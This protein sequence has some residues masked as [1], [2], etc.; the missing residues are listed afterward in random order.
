MAYGTVKVNFITFDAGSGDQTITVADLSSLLTS[1]ITVTGAINAQSINATSGTFTNVSGNTGRINT[2]TGTTASF[3]TGL[4]PN[5]SGSYVQYASGQI[6]NLSG[7]VVSYTSG[8]ITNVSG[9]YFEYVS[10][11][12]TTLSGTTLIGTL[13]GNAD[14]AARLTSAQNFTLSGDIT[15]T[16]SSN[17]ASGFVINTSFTSGIIVNDDISAGANIADTKLGTISTAGKVSNSATT[18]TSANTSSAIVARD[19]AGNFSANIIT[20]TLSGSCT[21]NAATA[22][23]LSSARNFALTGDV[24]GTVSSD[25]TTGFSVNTAIASG[26][27]V[28]ADINASAGIV[29][30]KLATITTVGKVANSATTATSANTVSTIVARDGL[31]NFSAGVITATL[32]G[33]ASTTTQLSSARTFSITGDVIGSVSSDLATGADITVGIASGVIV[34]A[35]INAAAAI[36]P[37]KLGTGA[38]P[39]SVTVAS[40]NIVDG[41]IVNNDINASAGIVDTKLATITTSGKVANSATTATSDNTASA[42][43][44]RDA[45][46]NVNVTSINGGPFA[47]YRNVIING[48]FDVWQRSTT[49]TGTGYVAADRWYNNRSVSAC[50][51]SRQAFTLGQTSVPGEPTYYCRMAVTSVSGAANASVLTQRI[52]DVR[53]F[54]GQQ[55]TLSFWA[56]ADGTKPIAVELVRI[57]GSGVSASAAETG[58]ASTQRTLTTSWQKITVT[59][60]L[61]TIS[62]KT[63][64]AEGESY[65]GVNIWMDAGS[66][67]NAR[68]ASIGQQSG[69]FDF[70]EFQFEPGPEDTTFERRP[71]ST[72]LQ[73]CQRYFRGPVESEAMGAGANGTRY[74]PAAGGNRYVGHITLSPPMR[75]APSISLNTSGIVYNN[76]SGLAA[77]GSNANGNLFYVVPLAAGAYAAS[78]WFASFDAEV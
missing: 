2:L 51:M 66:S 4:F 46:G 32:S 15:G 12:V 49:A 10:G 77:G 31:G 59:H 48:G 14:S 39:T 44:A 71:Y 61:P 62:G 27:I 47:G 19:G 18:A 7:N 20:A 1:G 58:I 52:E 5:I 50:T 25:L 37:S 67:Y 36:D 30:T 24:S 6:L 70:A 29:D 11:V 63:I 78:A 22:T 9:N 41:S 76:C 55:C 38:L 65:L 40:A 3:A 57:Y 16:V 68:A 74:T 33:N 28:N 69:T 35:D 56:K 54:A 60:T 53:T 75:A 34:N 23:S 26:V 13:S 42:I 72:E 73:L 21:G 64:D 43:V 45:N 17:L 8:N